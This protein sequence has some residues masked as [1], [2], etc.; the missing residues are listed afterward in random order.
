MPCPLLWLSVA[1]RD[2]LGGRRTLRQI[3]SRPAPGGGGRKLKVPVAISQGILILAILE[4]SSERNQCPLGLC[5]AE[6][7]DGCLL[8]VFHFDQPHRPPLEYNVGLGVWLVLR[9]WGGLTED[10]FQKLF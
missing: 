4:N 5:C 10:T 8:R 7:H 1:P 2:R 9:D 6:W 3:I